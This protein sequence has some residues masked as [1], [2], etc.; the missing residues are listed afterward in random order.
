MADIHNGTLVAGVV[1]TIT[2]AAYLQQITISSRSKALD[3][4]WFTSDGSTPQ[5]N[6]DGT[7]WTSGVSVIG[8][9]SYSSTTTIKLLCASAIGYSVK[10]E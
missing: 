8:A 6:T 4:L 7:G 1:T 9:P 2:V 10:G 5:A 3:D